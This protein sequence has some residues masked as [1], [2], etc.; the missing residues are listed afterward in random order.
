MRITKAMRKIVATVGRYAFA[1]AQGYCLAGVLLLVYYCDLVFTGS[2]SVQGDFVFW[3]EGKQIFSVPEMTLVKPWLFLLLA[4]SLIYLAGRVAIRAWEI[5]R[6]TRRLRADLFAPSDEAARQ[7]VA[8]CE[9]Q[10]E[11]ALQPA[12]IPALLAHFQRYGYAPTQH[13]DR[14]H[15]CRRVWP[16]LGRLILQLGFL[17]LGIGFL[18][19]FLL[20]QTWVFTV[21]EQAVATPDG[22][23]INPYAWR[24]SEAMRRTSPP[25]D[26]A[27]QLERVGIRPGR[28][29][30]Q[31]DAAAPLQGLAMAE[32]AIMA[33]GQT[34]LE[35]LT[36]KAFPPV[37]YGA[38][39]LHLLGA[40][41]APGI[42]IRQGT[43][44]I[45]GMF[46]ILPIFQFGEP[47]EFELQ[48]LP[49]RFTVELVAPLA[50]DGDHVERLRQA[51]V[52][53]SITEGSQIVYQGTVQQKQ[54]IAFGT[55]EMMIPELRL[56]VEISAIRDP[57]ILLGKLGL[58]AIALGILISLWLALLTTGRQDLFM[59]VCHQGETVKV[60]I[61]GK[62]PRLTWWFRRRVHKMLTTA[63]IG[64]IVQL[65]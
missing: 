13:Q 43:R 12:E 11:L 42:A 20:R 31:A 3:F 57:G 19:S 50:A 54:I 47:G 33:P 49:Y 15:G 40:G 21:G 9:V 65:C 26:W 17:L 2:L 38:Y 53:L 45:H 18:T 5:V 58:I 37:T 27:A 30:G 10:A 32:L 14:Y 63:G 23:A 62:T 36:V 29:R 4:W 1:P 34:T 60:T 35:P 56:W 6:V 44:S 48:G 39:Q 64:S 41:V 46:Q 55:Y 24:Q 51:T 22:T 52:K 16:E 25:L 7:W 28:G 59:T 61:A 8:A